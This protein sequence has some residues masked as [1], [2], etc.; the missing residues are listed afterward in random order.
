MKRF[1]PTLFALTL[2]VATSPVRAQSSAPLL[3]LPV[4]EGLA[5][6][7]NL[8]VVTSP[9]VSG[10]LSN[11]LVSIPRLVRPIAGFPEAT[12]GGLPGIDGLDLSQQAMRPGLD[13][14]DPDLLR[15][16]LRSLDPRVVRKI[17]RD[18]STELPGL[19][20]TPSQ[21]PITLPGLDGLPINLTR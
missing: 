16:L 4:V 19:G 10:L 13:G 1:L 6:I 15:N 17:S 2:L 3:E 18:I 7:L 11:S 12:T 20:D 5:T 14:L 8:P 9:L 21:Q